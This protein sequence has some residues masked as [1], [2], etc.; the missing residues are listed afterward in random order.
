ME[1]N[2]ELL[3]FYTHDMLMEFRLNMTPSYR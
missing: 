2:V 1:S 3:G